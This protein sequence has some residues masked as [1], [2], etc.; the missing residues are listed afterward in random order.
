MKRKILLLVSGIFAGIV[1]YCGWLN[2]PENRWNMSMLDNS[3]VLTALFNGTYSDSN[4]PVSRLVLADFDNPTIYRFITDNSVKPY[5]AKFS[6]DKRLLIFGDELNEPKDIGPQLVLMSIED[7]SIEHLYDGNNYELWGHTP[8]W[9]H[10]NSGFYYKRKNFGAQD[11]LFYQFSDRSDTRIHWAHGWS[12]YAVGMKGPDTLIVFSNNTAETGQPIGLYFMDL[13]GNYLSRIDNPYLRSTIDGVTIKSYFPNWN[14]EIGLFV[15]S[16]INSTISGYRISVTDLEGTYYKHYT[17]GG[18]IDQYP[19]WGPGG[20]YILFERLP[21]STVTDPVT[22]KDT[23]VMIIDCETGS[24]RE[25][26]A[27]K[28]VGGAVAIMHP[29]F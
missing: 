23:K 26:V 9:N 3:V 7:N 25:F 13:D 6:Q 4:E 29:V 1:F 27:A 10:D 19:V 17:Y 18:T 28:A 8:V 24:T 14:N 20:K 11:I 21:M 22:R 16:E 5:R 12:V 2:G 15:Y